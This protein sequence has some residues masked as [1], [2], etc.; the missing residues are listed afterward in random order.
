[1]LALGSYQRDLNKYLVKFN[2]Y[3][4]KQKAIHFNGH[5]HSDVYDFWKLFYDL[6]LF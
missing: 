3:D 5:V 6:T 1:M 4:A 2:A